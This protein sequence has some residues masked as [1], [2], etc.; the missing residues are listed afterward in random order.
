MVKSEVT[1]EARD[2]SEPV[3]VRSRVVLRT[4]KVSVFLH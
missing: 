4:V 2:P 1:P 3:N